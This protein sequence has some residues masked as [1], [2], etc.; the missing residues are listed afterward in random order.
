M[1][2]YKFNFW[3]DCNKD[4]EL[5][6]AE[7]VDQLKRERLFTRTIRDGIRLIADLRA[8]RLDVLFEL[9]PW[10]RAEFMAT[11]SPTTDIQ[12]QLARLE[13]LLLAQ[14]HQPVAHVTPDSGRGGPKPLGTRPPATPVNDDDDFPELVV[15]KQ[16]D[17]H[18]VAHNFLRS[19]F[20]LQG[21]E[22]KGDQR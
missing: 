14:G 10:V 21:I 15:K 5:L 13:T 2:R 17:N 7:Q 18:Q 11:L 3:L 6:L 16:A 1:A 12:Q 20:A 22:Y 19:V 9:F 8:G 4:D